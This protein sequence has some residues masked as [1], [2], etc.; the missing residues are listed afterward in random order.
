MLTMYSTSWCGYCHR[1]KSQLDREGI[2]YAVVDIESDPVSA[3]F[4]MSVN[5]GNQTVPT[6]RFDDGSALTNP[7]IVQVKAHLQT[8]AV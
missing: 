1:L 7:S 6:L 4:V 2:E 3:E 8:L 5:G